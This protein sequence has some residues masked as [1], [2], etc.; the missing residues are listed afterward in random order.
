[1]V[2]GGDKNR[3][4][5][6]RM[7]GQIPKRIPRYRTTAHFIYQPPAIQER[8][9]ACEFRN[10]ALYEKRCCYWI[11]RLNGAFGTIAVRCQVTLNTTFLMLGISFWLCI[12]WYGEEQNNSD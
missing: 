6:N 5:R 12:W 8:C 4:T 10:G 2:V 3:K 1:M 11:V 7:T 9:E